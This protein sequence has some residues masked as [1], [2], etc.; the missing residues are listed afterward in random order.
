MD[1]EANLP[2]PMIQPEKVA[3]AILGAAVRPTRAVKVGAMSK[4]N[5]FVAKNLPGVG[6]RMAARQVE[7]FKRDEPPAHAEGTLYIPGESGE[8]HGHHPTA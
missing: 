2:T 7:S 4:I 6:D 5:T 8:T 1:R 3:E